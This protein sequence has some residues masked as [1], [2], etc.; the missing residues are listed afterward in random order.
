MTHAPRD[1]LAPLVDAVS[2]ATRAHSAPADLLA[3][4][5]PLMA[6]LVTGDPEG[7]RRFVDALSWPAPDDPMYRRVRV[8][9]G[10]DGAW[11]LYAI[12]WREGQETPIHDHGTWGVVVVLA[13]TLVERMMTRVD[14]GRGDEGVELTPTGVCILQPGAV[15]TFMA[16]PDHI[17]RTGPLRGRAAS[18][19]LYGR[20][21]TSYNMYDLD[22]KTRRPLPVE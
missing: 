5:A 3:S 7:A 2:A 9:E 1:F 18:L 19:H 14:G 8:R 21:M 12:T 22:A 11:S 4:C 6:D 13:G 10:V 20:L 17:H 15:N 16:E